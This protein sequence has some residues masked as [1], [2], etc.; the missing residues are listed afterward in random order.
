[1]VV[2]MDCN[3]EA[4]RII[5][6]RCPSCWTR[7]LIANPSKYRKIEE[8]RPVI[9]EVEYIRPPKR[10]PVTLHVTGY[11]GEE[12]E[13][14]SAFHTSTLMDE[15]KGAGRL[16]TTKLTPA[17]EPI[18]QAKRVPKRNTG[19][20]KNGKK[21]KCPRHNITVDELG[22]CPECH[23][24]VVRRFNKAGNVHTVFTYEKRPARDRYTR[25]ET[26]KI[27]TKKDGLKIPVADLAWDDEWLRDEPIGKINFNGR[28]NKKGNG[29][30]IVFINY[31]ISRTNN[32]ETLYYGSQET[33][34][35]RVKKDLY[36][37]E[38]G[39]KTTLTDTRRGETLCPQCGLVKD[40]VMI[41]QRN[42]RGGSDD[43]DYGDD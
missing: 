20:T 18:R 12:T 36:Q 1:M 6:D 2:C 25:P 22:Y 37:C 27:Y 24:K 35:N 31:N 10:D 23:K 28:V 43:R 30:S 11:F 29:P 15:E 41:A 17:L 7:E 14:N 5:N 32:D 38:C 16:N 34:V 21:P 3:K 33:K 40:K 26:A 39:C 8:Q 4:E 42:S 13:L 19:W 9:N